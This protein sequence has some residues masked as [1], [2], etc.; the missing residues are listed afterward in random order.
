MP[1]PSGLAGITG[2]VIQNA[3]ASP[4]A[5]HGGFVDPKHAEWG[6]TDRP[7]PWENYTFG[8]GPHGPYGLENQLLG[9]DNA[10]EN[11]TFPAGQLVQD[12]TADLTPSNHAA[13]YP[14]EGPLSGNGSCDPDDTT[15]QLLQSA[16]IHGTRMGSGRR[17]LYDPTM[18]ALNDSWT[19]FYELNPGASTQMPITPQVGNASGGWGSTDREQNALTRQNTYGFDSAHM[20]RRYATGAIPGNYMWLQPGSRPLV[21]TF[22]GGPVNFPIGQDSPFTGDNPGATFGYQG[23]VLVNT[24]TQYSP[25]PEPNVVPMAWDSSGGTMTTGEW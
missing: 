11:R 7:Y 15:R 18:H 23:V 17:R 10:P 1:G 12:P 20:H 13:P 14:R 4:E 2:F 5:V 24:P 8:T 9:T 21:R 3:E 25:V 16:W 6:E 19:D 22:T